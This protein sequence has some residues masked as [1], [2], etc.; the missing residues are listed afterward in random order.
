MSIVQISQ[1]LDMSVDKELKQTNTFCKHRLKKMHLMVLQI[2]KQDNAYEW[3]VDVICVYET[4]D[5]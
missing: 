2:Y 5:L 3:D 1:Y 4:R